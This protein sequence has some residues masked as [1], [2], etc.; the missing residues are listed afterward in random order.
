MH[1]GVRVEL[2]HNF[3]N[4]TQ[5]R[6]DR[7]TVDRA[8]IALPADREIEQST[9]NR[10]TTLDIDYSPTADWGFN[11]QLPYINR[12]H[13]T[14]VEGDTD[15]SGSQSN[16]IGDVKLVARYQGFTPMRNIGL[17]FGLKL[18]TGDY[19]TNFNRGPQQGK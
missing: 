11:V 15:S 19:K 10:T 3:L 17:Q 16:H 18:P 14:I 1:P 8:A 13:T 9:I 4:Q 6:T 5:L 12:S 2:R 7:G